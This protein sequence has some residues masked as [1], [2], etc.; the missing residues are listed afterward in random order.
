MT[1]PE[2]T[3]GGDWSERGRRDWPEEDLSVSESV[4]DGF[5]EH[6]VVKLSFVFSCNLIFTKK[7]K[8]VSKKVGN[9][10]N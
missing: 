6:P 8:Q 9:R 4:D 2:H 1:D 5:S 3:L 10:R 7:V